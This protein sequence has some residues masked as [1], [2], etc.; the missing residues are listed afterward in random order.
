MEFWLLCNEPRQENQGQ[1]SLLTLDRTLHTPSWS[2][3]GPKILI[4]NTVVFD[5]PY[6]VLNSMRCEKHHTRFSRYIIFHLCSGS[7]HVNP[8]VPR[9]ESSFWAECTECYWSKWSWNVELCWKTN[10][11]HAHVLHCVISSTL[12]CHTEKIVL[13]TC[14]PQLPKFPLCI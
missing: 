9:Q 8:Q 6:L 11:N 1:G 13:F 14:R 3:H 7:H 4:P 10:S 2:Q 12:S 5:T